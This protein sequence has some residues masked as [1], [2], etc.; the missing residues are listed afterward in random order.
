[1]APRSGGPLGREK[2]QLMTP[3]TFPHFAEGRRGEYITEDQCVAICRSYRA[4]EG[5]AVK[6]DVFRLAY[7]IGVR[8]G[9]LRNA[10]KRHVLIVGDT[11]KLRWPKEETKSKW[12]AHE[13][14]LVGEELAIVQHAW[15]NRLTDCDFLFHI[16]GKPLGPMHSE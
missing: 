4:K 11:W 8:K 9:R 1:M 3:L 10:R 7:L 2:L 6:A 14:V 15:A 12:H 5:A 13:V 16:D